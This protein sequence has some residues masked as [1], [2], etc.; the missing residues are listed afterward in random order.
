M[1]YRTI[2]SGF[3]P[4]LAERESFEASARPRVDQAAMASTLGA[5]GAAQAM[6]DVAAKFD[7]VSP[8]HGWLG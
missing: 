3:T 6:L 4:I 2:Q 8:Q 7:D 5:S 1:F